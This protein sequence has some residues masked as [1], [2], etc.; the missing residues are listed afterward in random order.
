[1]IFF[2]L[3]IEKA[4][5]YFKPT[6]SK[7]SDTG[8][9][10]ALSILFSLFSLITKLIP[11]EGF[12]VIEINWFIYIYLI[13]RTNLF[14]TLIG[15]TA[16]SWLRLAYF[17]G[18]EPIGVCVLWLADFVE[19]ILVDMLFYIILKSK[20]NKEKKF[21]F[22]KLRAKIMFFILFVVPSAICASIMCMFNYFI[23][24][25]IYG[26]SGLKHSSHF[27]WILTGFIICKYYVNLLIFLATQ[28]ALKYL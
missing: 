18:S 26:V 28:R 16:A 23:F 24:L 8:L 10:V 17:P 13:L 12:L 25:D 5:N 1:M 7:I 14:Y 11:F 27:F 22:L 21:A 6:V 4:V 9:C 15:V 20:D 19:I 3:K 2:R